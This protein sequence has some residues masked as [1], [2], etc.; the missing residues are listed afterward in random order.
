MSFAQAMSPDDA[1]RLVP[2]RAV[3]AISSSSGLNTPDRVLRALG[4]R[5][6]REGRPRGL[7][8]VHPIGSGDMYG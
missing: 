2:D 1:A 5:F 3:V 8:T 4:E 7:T 6:A